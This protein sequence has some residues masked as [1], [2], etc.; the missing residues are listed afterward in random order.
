M[1]SVGVPR[2]AVWFTVI[3]VLETL[4]SAAGIARQVMAPS[5]CLLMG[6][7]ANI[8]GWLADYCYTQFLVL[9]GQARP[10]IKYRVVC[11]DLYKSLFCLLGGSELNPV[12]SGDI[13]ELLCWHAFEHNRGELILAI[14]WHSV[15][16]GLHP[17]SETSSE[18]IEKAKIENRN[19]FDLF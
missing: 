6:P 10:T 17:P 1:K 3:L 16:R 7:T 15:N 19:V 13:L 2:A 8:G 5:G 14:V 9:S 18:H 4:A 11:N 12:R